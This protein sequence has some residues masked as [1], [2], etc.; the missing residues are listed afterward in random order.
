MVSPV[1]FNQTFKEKGIDNLTQT[2]P[3]N[4]KIMNNPNLLYEASL[5]LQSK[6]DKEKKESDKVISRNQNY[7]PVSLMN[8]DFFKNTSKMKSATTYKENKTS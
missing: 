3:E 5:I 6:S 2:F 8:I 7:K 4:T 1:D